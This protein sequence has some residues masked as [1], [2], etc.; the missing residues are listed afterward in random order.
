MM[1]AKQRELQ[2]Q[3]AKTLLQNNDPQRLPVVAYKRDRMF[4]SKDVLTARALKE[5]PVE[6]H[7]RNPH[8][9][10]LSQIESFI[11]LINE[12]AAAQEAAKARTA[13]QPQEM[14][15]PKG[16]KSRWGN[17][18]TTAPLAASAKAKKPPSIASI[19]KSR[20]LPSGAIIIK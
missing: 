5:S 1:K 8:T 10:Y 16:E 20:L 6:V 11:V 18:K 9:T 14:A 12:V 19:P 15:R 4:L 3:L 7:K 17:A 13:K 2:R